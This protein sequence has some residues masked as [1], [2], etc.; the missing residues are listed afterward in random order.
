[1]LTIITPTFNRGYILE[2]A[3]LSLKNQTNF[4]FEWI[5][6]DDGSSDNTNI[7]VENWKKEV[8]DFS[9]NYLKTKNGGKHRAVNK[10][11][12]LASGEYILILDS[13]D[14]L[15][16]NAV[17]KIHMWFNTINGK[18]DFAGVAGMK[19]HILSNSQIGDNLDVEYVDATNIERKKFKL[20]GDKAEV[21]YTNIMKLY[22]FPEFEGENFIRESVVWDKIALDGYKIRWYN[23]VIYKCDYLDDGLTKNSN[24]KLYIQNFNGFQLMVK[25]AV[26]TQRFPSRNIKIGYYNSIAK[27]KGLKTKKIC[28][29][30]GITKVTLA[31]SILMYRIRNLVKRF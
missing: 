30:L 5:I 25:I 18:K 20:C 16:P 14:Y 24:D 11:V 1:M 31:F 23:E 15:L 17:E 21:L 12:L 2:K 26:K 22:P 7:L 27:K 4:D 28:K 29:E 6:I 9:I 3:Y 8:N 10:G 19:G 13:D